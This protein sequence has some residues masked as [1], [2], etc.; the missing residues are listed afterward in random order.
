[1]IDVKQAVQFAANYVKELYEPQQLNDM[2]LEE[3]ERAEDGAHWLI[4]LS[5]E[6][7][8]KRRKSKLSE[9]VNQPPTRDYK[10]LKIN[11]TSGEVQSMKIRS[12]ET[13]PVS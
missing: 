6:R 10:I 9:I 7:S 4:T 5:F 2:R 1:M 3:T 13:A 11:A 8:T 12:T